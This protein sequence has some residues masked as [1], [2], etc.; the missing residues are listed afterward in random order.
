MK[1]ICAVLLLVAATAAQ[2]EP[3]PETK[4]SVTVRRVPVDV[5]VTDSHDRAINDLTKAD[6]ELLEDGKPQEI[7]AFSLEHEGS[8]TA[9]TVRL[10]EGFVSNSGLLWNADLT[11]ILFDELNTPFQSLNYART[12]LENLLKDEALRGRQLALVAL[13]GDLIPIHEFTTEPADIIAA[14][15][16][17][18]TYLPQIGPGIGRSPIVRR[19]ELTLSALQLIS[20]SLRY[21]PGRKR[22]LW[23]SGGFPV[24]FTDGGVA[25]AEG[26]LVD[27]VRAASVALT[28]ARVSVYP[29]SPSTMDTENAF[30]P[31]SDARFYNSFTM[32]DI[33]EQTGGKYYRNTNNLLRVAKEAMDDGN[34]YYALTYRPAESKP[35]KYRHIEVKVKRQ[36]ARVRFRHGYWEEKAEDAGTRTPPLRSAALE[37]FLRNEIAFA[38]SA[39]RGQDGIQVTL[40]LSPKSLLLPAESADTVRKFQIVAMERN[41]TMKPEVSKP[42]DVE[43]RIKATQFDRVR[44]GGLPIRV[45]LPIKG[46]AD[47]VRIVLYDIENGRIGSLDIPLQPMRS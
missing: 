5:V 39:L 40:I 22:L 25:Q 9:P 3:A 17:H 26:A 12:E 1:T 32:V 44:A 43:L 47:M 19:S 31:L 45:T 4:I 46:K 15:R 2:Q 37:P 41:Q 16:R 21:R 24:S 8:V 18:K 30:L 29:I 13:N 7:T 11:V 35:G 38:A 28:S 42:E 33:A 36:G 20:Q 27:A 34:S 14:F 10:P 6:F 23:F